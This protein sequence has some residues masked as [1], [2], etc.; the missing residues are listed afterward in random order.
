LVSLSIGALLLLLPI[1]LNYYTPAWNRFLKTV[2]VIA[3][4]TQ[5]TRWFCMYI[6]VLTLLTGVAAVK[7]PFWRRSHKTIAVAGIAGIIALN[8]T[9]DKSYY[10]QESYSPLPIMSTYY[11]VRWE[12][13]EPAITKI[14]V[15]TD[16]YGRP[17]ISV[18]RDDSLVVGVSQMWCYDSVFGYGLENLPFKQ[19]E[20]GSVFK[21]KNGYL[22]IKNPA[23]YVFPEVNDC[24]P[25]DHF[26]ICEQ[27]K[28]M[29]FTHYRPYDFEM[30]FLQKIANRVTVISLFLAGA[31]LVFFAGGAGL[32][33]W[34]QRTGSTKEN[35]T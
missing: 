21:E 8:L 5:C 14:G 17:G 19:L 12:K 28:A 30:T 26:K 11:K 10:Q 4:S 34:R 13:W 18:Q 35:Q 3:S 2:P 16:R 32:A 7:T 1:A 15:C 23:C 33:F 24:L 22:N 9:A 27:K 31:F 25:G 20:V 6:P 29:A